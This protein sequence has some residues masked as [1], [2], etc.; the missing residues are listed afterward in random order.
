MFE[1]PPLFNLIQEESKT[2]WREMYKVFNMGH[3]FEFYVPEEIVDDIIEISDHYNVEAKV[4]GKVEEMEN[5]KEVVIRSKK[6][7]FI[8]Q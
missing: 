7:E 1:I 5:G 8:Y 3:R 2:D 4:I 6:G